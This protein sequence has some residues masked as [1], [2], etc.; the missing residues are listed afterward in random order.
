MSNEWYT[1]SKYIEAAREV[2]GSIDLD[3]ASCALANQT[4]RAMRYYSEYDN[5]LAQ[6]WIARNVWLN[7]PYGRTEAYG[8]NIKLF[9]EKLISEY[10]LGHIEQAILLSSGKVD[11][12]WF[13]PLWEFPI[14]F[15]NH[16][17]RFKRNYDTPGKPGR[18]TEGHMHGTIFVY[19]GW[20]EY[21]FTEV[22]SQFGRIVK[23]IDVKVERPRQLELVS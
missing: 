22:F 18:Y 14:C 20:N 16:C 13:Q 5:G 12:S 10:Q 3:P 21:R 4:V 9:T 6:E 17:V 1:P 23:A 19:F 8:S 7:P 11:A 15:S 2:M